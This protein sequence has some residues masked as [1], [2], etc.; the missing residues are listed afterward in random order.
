M[1]VC[2]R[3]LEDEG[4]GVQVVFAEPLSLGVGGYF[5]QKDR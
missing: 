2:K 3:A 4:G 1:C 5:E